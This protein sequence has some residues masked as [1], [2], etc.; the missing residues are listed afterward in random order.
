MFHMDGLAIQHRSMASEMSVRLTCVWLV[1]RLARL[2]SLIGLVDVGLVRLA[3]LVEVRLTGFYVSL[4]AFEVL[5]SA[6]VVVTLYTSCLARV[7]FIVV[8]LCKSVN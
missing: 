5:V 7:T 4:V 1:V 8:A 3:R 2:V 6:V